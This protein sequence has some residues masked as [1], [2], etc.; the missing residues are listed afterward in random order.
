MQSA[1]SVSSFMPVVG[2]V[3]SVSLGSASSGRLPQGASCSPRS[4]RSETHSC[5]FKGCSNLTT[6]SFSTYQHSPVEPGVG[7]LKLCQAGTFPAFESSRTHLHL[8]ASA[9]SLSSFIHLQDVRLIV[10]SPLAPAKCTAL[11][12]FRFQQRDTRPTRSIKKAPMSVPY[13]SLVQ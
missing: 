11:S 6:T 8:T 3:R 1:L 7:A 2:P 13:L 10:L 9:R 4:S 12:Y 5:G